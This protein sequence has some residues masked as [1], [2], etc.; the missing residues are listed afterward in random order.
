MQ[1]IVA[2]NP[3]H[4][5]DLLRGQGVQVESI[6]P[7][8]DRLLVHSDAWS[9]SNWQSRIRHFVDGLVAR[10]L[11]AQV[12]WFTR[13]LSTLL[14]VGTPM[15]DAF[16]LVIEQSKG[17]F[18]YLLLDIRE[19][20]TGGS[21]LGNAVRRHSQVFDPVLCEMITVGEQSGAL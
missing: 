1:T 6:R 2:D 13:E 9:K 21:S 5:R 14:R 11:S 16:Q 17:R 12:T 7:I 10:R 3:R 20:L 18:R 15:V 19:Q 8:Q 4:A